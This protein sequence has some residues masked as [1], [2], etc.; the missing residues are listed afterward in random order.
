MSQLRSLQSL[1][2][3]TRSISIIVHHRPDGDAIGSAVALRNA[4]RQSHQI[5]II[6]SSPIPQIFTSILGEVPIERVLPNDS[7]L[8]VI[9][10]CAELHRTGFSKQ[11]QRIIKSGKSVISFDHHPDGDLQK[12]T[13]LRYWNGQAAA[14]TE[15]IF[16]YLNQLRIPIVA[17]TATALLLGIYTDTGGFRHQTTSSDTLRIASRLVR[18]GADLQKMSTAF[19]RQ[20]SRPKQRLWGT[21]LSEITINRFGIV[22]ALVPQRYLESAGST[23]EDIS[24]LANLLSLTEEA[25]A[26]LVLI[27]TS[28]GWRGMLR[29]RFSS[30]DLGRLARL[31]GGSGHKKA[32][33]FLATK[34]VF[35]GKINK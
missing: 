31:F 22:V 5:R 21:I 13:T 29:T 25:K 18:L 30:V 12:M 34:Q 17:E 1:L 23:V 14:T 20:L 8:Y 26:S 7:D 16:E 10:D 35:L 28:E 11:L 9:V 2:G 15:V 4:L 19:C 27:E 3:N 32:A 6:S 33:G 24:G